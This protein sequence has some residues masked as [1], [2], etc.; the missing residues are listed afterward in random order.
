MNVIL[1]RACARCNLV[2]CIC[3]Q[4]L[5]KNMVYCNISESNQLTFDRGSCKMKQKK[6]GAIR[7]V[8]FLLHLV[9][10]VFARKNSGRL[11]T[12]TLY[13]F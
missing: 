3:V 6:A 5:T 13:L 9:H 4:I 2:C 7:C 10:T 1:L 12:K 8:C 11:T